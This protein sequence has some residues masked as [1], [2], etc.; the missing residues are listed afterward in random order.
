LP[1]S[2]VRPQLPI[3]IV[4]EE[5]IDMYGLSCAK[6]SAWIAAASE[7]L[8]AASTSPHDPAFMLYTSGSGGTPQGGGASPCGHVGY[9]QELCAYRSRPPR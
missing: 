7:E 3:V 6:W 8:A 4:G 1:A 2:S 5:R 9:Q